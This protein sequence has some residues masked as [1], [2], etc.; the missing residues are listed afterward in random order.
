MTTALV[1]GSA[2]GLMTVISR[3][4]R[5]DPTPAAPALDVAGRHR[6]E[7]HVLGERSHCKNALCGDPGRLWAPSHRRIGSLGNPR[8]RSPI[9]LRVISD[10]PPAIDSAL[11]P[12]LENAAEAPGPSVKT[13][14]GPA[15]AARMGAR[16]GF[17]SASRSFGTLPSGAGR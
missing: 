16:A 12:R 5:A 9:W 15:R 8:M 13:T 6:H 11:L 2:K 4:R 1:S 7:P 10:V 17:W 14:S 3:G